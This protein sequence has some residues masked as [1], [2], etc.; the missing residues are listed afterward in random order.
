MTTSTPSLQPQIEQAADAAERLSNSAEQAVSGVRERVLPAAV[1]L[2]SQAEDLAQ[3]GYHAV[4]DGS[5]HL[6]ERAVDARERGVR[7]VQEEP[8]KAVLIAAATGAALMALVQLVSHRRG[9]RR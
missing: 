7:Y 9:D 2:A 5:Q 6:R 8:I 3:R 4:R 1:R